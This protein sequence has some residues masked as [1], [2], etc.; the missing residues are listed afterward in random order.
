MNTITNTMLRTWRCSAAVVLAL[1]GC[2]G[3]KP[4]TVKNTSDLVSAP[5]PVPSK[6][7]TTTQVEDSTAGL[8][9]EVANANVEVKKAR[10]ASVNAVAEA[11]NLAALVEKAYAEADEARKVL[12]ETVKASAEENARMAEETS[13]ALEAANKAVE[14]ATAKS[15]TL[16]GQVNEL[17]KNVTDLRAERDNW[18]AAA[19]NNAERLVTAERDKNAAKN[20]LDLA[21]EKV[22]GADGVLSE[23]KNSR[24]R[25]MICSAVELVALIGVGYLAFKP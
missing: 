2:T 11:R 5:S 9:R 17:A 13:A 7:F 22:A 21:N 6:P 10:Q 20:A 8:R 23:V 24:F 16:Q 3:L 12:M 15:E 1:A 18:K 4:V 14:G 25:W 19:D